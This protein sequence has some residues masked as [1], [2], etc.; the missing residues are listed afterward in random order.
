MGNIT[1]VDDVANALGAPLTEW[2]NMY[3]APSQPVYEFCDALEVKGN[4]S[5]S[6]SGWGLEHALSAWGTYMQNVYGFPDDESNGSHDGSLAK[7]TNTSL[8]QMARSWGWLVCNELGWFQV[9]APEGHPS[10][11]SRHLD[12]AHEMRE[13]CQF[14]FPKTFGQG[15]SP[16][17]DEI[18]AKF[19][20]WDVHVDRVFFAN[21]I[22]DPWLDATVSSSSID[23]HSTPLTPVFVGKGFHCSDLQIAAAVEPTIAYI[24]EKA[25]TYIQAWLADW[26]Q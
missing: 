25:V 10:I 14:P 22:N 7:Y 21:G 11:V 4:Q 2:Q 9:G 24:Q 17:I 8:D 3:M 16:K 23:F 13:R 19:G 5:A 26:H 18:N 1:H 15:V 20:G 12:V 6:A